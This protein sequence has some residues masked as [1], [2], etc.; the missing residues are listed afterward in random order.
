M[1]ALNDL[2]SLAN[3]QTFVSLVG[4]YLLSSRGNKQRY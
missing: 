2:D 4:H 3:K 1:F